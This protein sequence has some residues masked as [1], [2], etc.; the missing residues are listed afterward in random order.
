MANNN[1]SESTDS[2]SSTISDADETIITTT[3]NNPPTVSEGLD[4]V[5]RAVDTDGSGSIDREEY[6]LHLSSA[7][8][9]EE[10]IRRSFLEI[11][12]D[13]NGEISRDELQRAVSDS[14]AEADRDNNSDCPMGY[15]LNSVE[16]RCE[17]LGPVGRI[18]QKIENLAPF[19]KGYKK[20]TNLFGVDR[21]AI[22]KQGVTFA[23]AYSIISNLNGAISLSVAWYM[24]VKRVSTYLVIL[25]C[26]VWD[27]RR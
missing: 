14:D 8:Y 6:N 17:E 25:S 18:S 19:R 9:S 7:G 20:I 2:S 11:D 12:R 15:W 16:R 23:L 4:R 3:T 1:E 13:G 22:Q 21:Q 27:I 10:A 24:T 5:F 26:A